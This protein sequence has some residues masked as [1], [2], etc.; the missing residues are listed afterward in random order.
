MMR[1]MYATRK[2][3][4]ERIMSLLVESGFI[5]CL[6]WLTQLVIFNKF[7]VSPAGS[8]A[9]DVLSSFGDQVSGMYPTLIIVIVNFQRTI[10]DE[11]AASINIRPRGTTSALSEFRC[12][13]PSDTFGGTTDFSS[14]PSKG[15]QGD[16]KE[17]FEMT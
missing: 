8:Y 17:S 7:P 10:W 16:G 4:T 6:F 5:Y 3:A 11:E 12:A 2:L 14:V 9:F 15:R 1:T 13:V